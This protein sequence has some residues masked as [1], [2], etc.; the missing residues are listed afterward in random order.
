MLKEIL[1]PRGVFQDLQQFTQPAILAPFPLTGT[2]GARHRLSE[3]ILVP[4]MRRDPEL[5]NLMHRAGANLN[6]DALVLRPDDPGMERAVAVRLRQRDVVLEAT[7]YHGITAM[8]D[9]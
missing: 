6:L 9:A 4:P 3:I 7:R 8:N 5:R 2:F 1:R